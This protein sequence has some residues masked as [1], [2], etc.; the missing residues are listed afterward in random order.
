MDPQDTYS[1]INYAPMDGKK[2]DFRYEVHG[3][4]ACT[5]I[6]NPE[7]TSLGLVI[8]EGLYSLTIPSNGRK[9]T[10]PSFQFSI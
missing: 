4:I 10:R 5:V 7:N 9:C 8:G 2:N 6:N 3:Y 1:V